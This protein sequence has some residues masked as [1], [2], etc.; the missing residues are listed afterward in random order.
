[1]ERTALRIGIL[2]IAGYGILWTID[3]DIPIPETVFTWVSSA[4]GVVFFVILPVVAG[5]RAWRGSGPTSFAG[6]VMALPRWLIQAWSAVDDP[7]TRVGLFAARLLLVAAAITIL[8]CTGP[9]TANDLRFQPGVAEHDLEN[10]RFV[11]A[12]FILA[13]TVLGLLA[14][15]FF[16]RLTFISAIV[17]LC[18]GSIEGAAVLYHRLVVPAASP[19]M[20]K[21]EGDGIWN[22][23]CGRMGLCLNPNTRVRVVGTVGDKT[24]YDAVYEAD[25]VGSRRSM[26]KEDAR[27]RPNFIAFFG[28]SNT[29][30]MTVNGPD[31]LPGQVAQLACD[32][33]PYNFAVEG[34]G[35]ANMLGAFDMGKVESGV[36]Q[37]QGYF[38][39]VFRDGHLWRN[40]GD[41]VSILWGKQFPAYDVDA[42]GA[43]T[44]RGTLW[45]YRPFRNAVSTLVDRLDAL[46]A[47]HVRYPFF[48]NKSETAL[49]TAI[50][51]KAYDLSQQQFPKSKFVV[52]LA[53]HTANAAT[54][55]FV[56]S[57]KGLP[58]RV[59][60]YGGLAPDDMAGTVT[61]YDRHPTALYHHI[62]AEHL[63]AD[64]GIESRCAE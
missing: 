23:V 3:G 7:P 45:T 44:Y 47:L 31:T 28:D 1:M 18:L 33:Q 51:S 2:L 20:V 34:G 6:A 12:M 59:L 25:E 16:V 21:S 62:F 32:Y 39:Y 9:L 13:P 30:G 11:L 15:T 8:I 63:A 57:L 24:I 61:P 49:G 55:A 48:F 53:A 40:I 5:L 58:V 50:L 29:F 26:P 19:L 27:P 46:S 35:T 54:E 38:I 41:S 10:P 17:V 22:P 36:K 52:L 64:L 14:I 43:V 4:V 37:K 42:S 56:Q 60:D